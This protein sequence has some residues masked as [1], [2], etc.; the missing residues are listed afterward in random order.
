MAELM[1]KDF[2]YIRALL[3]CILADLTVYV[4]VFEIETGCGLTHLEGFQ[5]HSGFS[6]AV[7]LL[8]SLCTI[9]MLELEAGCG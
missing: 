7:Y 6:H 2:K 9:D 1:G 3:S 8:I 4:Y 5:I